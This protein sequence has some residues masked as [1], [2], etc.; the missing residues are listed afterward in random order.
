MA[1]RTRWLALAATAMTA[2]ASAATAQSWEGYYYGAT[3][4]GGT[5]TYVPGVSAFREEGPDVDVDGIMLG[6]RA[7]RNFQSGNVVY[8][9][10]ADI[11]NGLSGRTPQGTLGPFWNCGSGDCNVSIGRLVT[12]RGRHGR[13][14]GPDTLIYGAAGL[15][16]AHVSGGIEGSIQQG[17]SNAI[18]L[19]LGAGV[20]RAYSPNINYFAEGSFTDLGELE[21]GSNNGTETFDAV[22]NFVTLKAGINVRF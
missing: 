4:G 10:D 5:G 2:L 17:S 3:L 19:T 15:A 14:A 1:K 6:L 12:V 16:F 22:G 9:F 11:S 20:E 7:G 13:L 8:G 18:G 21:F